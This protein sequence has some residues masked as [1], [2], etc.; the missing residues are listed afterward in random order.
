ML[1]SELSEDRV[2]L[3]HDALYTLQ[4]ICDGYHSAASISAFVPWDKHVIEQKKEM[5]DTYIRQMLTSSEAIWQNDEEYKSWSKILQSDIDSH[6]TRINCFTDDTTSIGMTADGRKPLTRAHAIQSFIMGLNVMD[7]FWTRLKDI[8][9]KR[10]GI[11]AE[12]RNIAQRA[13]LIS[14]GL[15]QFKPRDREP[16]LQMLR[17]AFMCLGTI[18]RYKELYSE[19]R[20]RPVAGQNVHRHQAGP[21]ARMRKY[22]VAREHFLMAFYLVPEDGRA[23]HEI[24]QLCLHA[25]ALESVALLYRS[26][27]AKTRCADALTTLQ[28]AF[29]QAIS[30]LESLLRRLGGNRP[31]ACAIPLQV[32]CLETNL[33]LLHASFNGG[34]SSRVYQMPT[35]SQIQKDFFNLVSGCHLPGQFICRVLILAMGIHHLAPAPSKMKSLHRSLYALSATEGILL[36][37]LLDMF[38]TLMDVAS[39]ALSQ[40]TAHEPKLAGQFWRTLPALRLMSQWLLPH[41]HYVLQCWRASYETNNMKRCQNI[42]NTWN[43]YASFARML[44]RTFNPRELPRFDDMAFEEDV[45]FQGFIPLGSPVV[46]TSDWSNVNDTDPSIKAQE[47]RSVENLARVADLLGRAEELAS[48][49]E[50]PIITHGHYIVMSPEWTVAGV[51]PPPTDVKFLVPARTTNDLILPSQRVSPLVLTSPKFTAQNAV[52]QS[53]NFV[54]E[55]AGDPIASYPKQ[56]DHDNNYRFANPIASVTPHGISGHPVRADVYSHLATKHISFFAGQGYFTINADVDSIRSSGFGQGS[57]ALNC[58]SEE[59]RPAMRTYQ[60]PI[61][62]SRPSVH[63]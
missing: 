16:F 41:C 31:D 58:D 1:D 33:L 19:G 24:V 51:P 54:Q 48:I 36:D 27:C 13:L 29:T 17:T 52:A 2:C 30:S 40:C 28:E 22:T 23:L 26:L 57:A 37:H 47:D 34:E 59:Y 56:P 18:A 8:V 50:S 43:N 45:K 5:Q 20:G 11:I 42:F 9:L 21:S 14:K 7:S 39:H 44:Q 49:R 61:G 62:T 35:G 12:A 60:A 63:G 4:A 38:T 55:E 46:S 15:Q 25:D 10:L 32:E 3:R 6:I 53:T